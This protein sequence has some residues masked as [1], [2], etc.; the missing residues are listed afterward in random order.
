MSV[1][2]CVFVYVC[3]HDYIDKIYIAQGCF[4]VVRSLLHFLFTIATPLIEG[5]WRCLMFMFAI[6]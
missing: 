3:A 4:V 6:L 5:W 1:Y 2:E